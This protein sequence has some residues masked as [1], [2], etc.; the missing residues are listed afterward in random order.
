MKKTSTTILMFAV[1]SFILA[2]NASVFNGII[3]QV[4][5]S[6]NIS[7]ANT[8][9]LNT[10]FA[11]GGAFGVPVSLILFHKIDRVKLLKVM[12]LTTILLTLGLVLTQDFTQLLI[13]RFMSG[14]SANTYNVLAISVVVSLS[15]KNRQGRTMALLIA[16]NATALVIGVPATRAL[17]SILGWREIFTIMTGIMTLC[18]VYFITYLKSQN[19]TQEGIKL[20]NELILMKDRETLTVLISTLVIFVGMG[21]LN[22]FLTPYLIDVVPNIEAS[23]SL[24]LVLIGVACFTGNYIGGQV[25]DKLGYKKSMLMG[26]SIQC[27]NVIALFLIQNLGWLNL[28]GVLL[29]LGTSWFIGLQINTGIAQATQNKSSFILALNASMVQLGSALGASLSVGIITNHGITYIIN[30]VLITIFA[31]LM[32]IIVGRSKLITRTKP[33]I[34]SDLQA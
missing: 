5:D 2:M 33:E 16:G 12:L 27:I 1:M 31:T 8:G 23:M 13:I 26:V 7:V 28:V 29:W 19:Q 11:Y 30:I 25:S 3:D 20:K 24:I 21:A 22:T 10:M 9:L 6:L 4:A 34:I 15:D 14:V 17:S 32:L 18:L